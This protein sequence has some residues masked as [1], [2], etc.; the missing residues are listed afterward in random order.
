MT[1]W[2]QVANHW[3]QNKANAEVTTREWTRVH[4][5]G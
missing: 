5:G 3:K 1:R 4:A 2:T